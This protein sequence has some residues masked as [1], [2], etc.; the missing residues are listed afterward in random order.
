MNDRSS[1]RRTM[2]DEETFGI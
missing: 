1:R 2:K